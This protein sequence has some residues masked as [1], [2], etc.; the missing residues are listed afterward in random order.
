MI[1]GANCCRCAIS[2]RITQMRH[3]LRAF[4]HDET[5]IECV[6]LVSLGKT[7]GDDARDSFE[8]QRGGS[9]FATRAGAEIDPA[10]TTSPF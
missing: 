7:A 1:S 5:V 8:L 3:E 2:E 10:T 6:A 4:E 9:L